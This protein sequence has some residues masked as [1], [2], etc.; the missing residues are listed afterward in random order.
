MECPAAAAAATVA[1]V[2][3]SLATKTEREPL[4]AA[5]GPAGVATATATDLAGHGVHPLII[6]IEPQSRGFIGRISGFLV[7]RCSAGR[8]GLPA[9]AGI[10]PM[11]MACEGRKERMNSSRN[12][13]LRLIFSTDRLPA[14]LSAPPS[15]RDLHFCLPETGPIPPL[16]SRD[17]GSKRADGGRGRTKGESE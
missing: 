5:A 9:A 16:T 1:T 4:S 13:Q 14:S 8:V 7:P 11:V 6:G 3:P 2:C 17:G 10:R 12:W 15:K